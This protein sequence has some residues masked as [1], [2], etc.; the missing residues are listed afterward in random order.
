[1]P[2]APVISC[3]A[4]IPQYVK[5]V[6]FFSSSGAPY[7]QRIQ[8]LPERVL[9][10]SRYPFSL[11]L[12]RELDL[13]LRRS[14]VFLIGENGSGKSTVLEAIAGLLNLPLSGG[15]TSDQGLR[16]GPSDDHDLSRALR[17]TF[18]RRPRDAYFFRGEFVSHF[19]QLLDERDADPDFRGDPYEQYG[20]KP[21]LAQSHG[22]G[23][24]AIMKNRLRE[25]LYLLDEPEAALS[26]Q[27]QLSMMALI[28][29]RADA[30]AQFIIA[31]HSPLLMTI[32]NAE[33]LLIENGMLSP[34][35]VEDTE[36]FQITKAVLQNPAAFWKHL[37]A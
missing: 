8:L 36:H 1:V 21:L 6:S 28:A 24:L 32:P 19:A 37:R 7:L 18:G 11:R 2:L 34:V 16:H 5:R 3:F 14:V 13:K 15:G 9:D 4:A 27:R 23:F 33:I 31:T 26:P 30:G 29:E 20:G 22:E 35:K 25:G 12:I 17:P 10:D